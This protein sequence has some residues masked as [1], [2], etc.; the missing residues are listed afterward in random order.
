MT[1]DATGSA[2]VSVTLGPAAGRLVGTIT[3]GG[4]VAGATVRAGAD[5]D[6]SEATTDAD[7]TFALDGLPPGQITVIIEADGFAPRTVVVDIVEGGE[8]VVA[9][10]LEPE[11]SG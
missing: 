7:G 5:D 2:A 8:T 1:L 11:T 10:A 9:I 4:P 3:A 6:A